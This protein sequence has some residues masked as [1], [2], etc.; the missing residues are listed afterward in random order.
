MGRLTSWFFFC[1]CLFCV[2][3]VGLFQSSGIMSHHGVA[4]I[5]ALL[6]YLSVLCSG[7][8]TLFGSRDNITPW[9]SWHPGPSFV[10]VF[11]VQEVGTFR[12]LGT[13]SHQEAAGI[14]ALLL[15]LSVLCAGGGPFS[16][17]R[18]HVTPRDGWHPGPY[19]NPSSP[20][21]VANRFV[22]FSCNRIKHML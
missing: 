8:W 2:Q 9:G 15:Y 12:S 1:T 19:F 16:V 10:L 6:L 4:G 7:G 17:P 3:E 13:L 21:L 5:P 18:D 14:L 11:Y 20:G 22:F